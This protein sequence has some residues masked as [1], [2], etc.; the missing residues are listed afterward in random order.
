[1]RGYI[2]H[3]RQQERN[4]AAACCPA[5]P[6]ATA[7]AERGRFPGPLPATTDPVGPN[8]GRTPRQLC[9]AARLPAAAAAA[10]IRRRCCGPPPAAAPGRSPALHCC[11]CRCGVAERAR[12]MTAERGLYTCCCCCCG[13]YR[14]RRAQQAQQ[15]E[16]TTARAS[17]GACT[18]R[19][20]VPLVRL[21][22]LMTPRPLLVAAVMTGLT[23]SDVRY[24]QLRGWRCNNRASPAGTGGSTGPPPSNHQV[25]G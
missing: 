13:G 21:S 19:G 20:W 10:V 3:A 6:A 18:L 15:P 11:C 23:D 1:M 16:P 17:Q 5:Q 24:A 25:P 14:Q 8:G 22:L 7:A 9:D 2:G 12:R 4:P